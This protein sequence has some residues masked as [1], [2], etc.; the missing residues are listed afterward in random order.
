M[1]LRLD[2]KAGKGTTAGFTIPDEVVAALGSSRRPAVK[3][4][5][6]GY[7]YRSSIARMG[8]KFMLGVSNDVRAASEVSPGQTLDVDIELDAEKREVAV[9]ED[10]AAALKAHPAAA[11]AFA[12][13]AYSHQRRHVEAINQA[14]ADE[15]RRRR[16]DRSIAEL[17][18]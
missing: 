13:L 10:F 18:G 2:L 11:A 16:I 12:K 6:N 9:P 14:K 5:L 17:A 1:R 3:V 8:D 7:T 4:T 15:T